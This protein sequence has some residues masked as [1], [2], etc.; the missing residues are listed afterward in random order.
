MLHYGENVRK[1]SGYNLSP[2]Y[3]ERANPIAYDDTPLKDEW[4]REVYLEADALATREGLASVLDIGCG[5]GYKLLANFPGLNT[6]GVEIEPTLSW[7]R[8][9]YPER[10][11]R[12]PEEVSGSW[13]LVVCSDVI[14]HVAD[15]DSLLESI[16]AVDPKWV[17]LSTP[18][19]SLIQGADPLG[20]PKNKAHIREWDFAEFGAYVSLHFD[21][22]RHFISNREQATQVVIAT[23]KA[24]P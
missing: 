13:D 9:T 4:Q 17:V 10:E 22:V 11:W 5:S 21:I 15:P 24:R 16:K 8:S 3:R 6:C 14:E 23:P 18:D 1:A 2:E 20:P 19:R 7:L 12:A